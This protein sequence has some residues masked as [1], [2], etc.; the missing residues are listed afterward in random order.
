MK[1]RAD[2]CSPGKNRSNYNLPEQWGNSWNFE[3]VDTQSAIHRR[4]DPA[5]LPRRSNNVGAKVWSLPR[6]TCKLRSRMAR[7]SKKIGFFREVAEEPRKAQVFGLLNGTVAGAKLSAPLDF[8]LSMRDLTSLRGVPEPHLKAL[9]DELYLLSRHKLFL[10][11]W[12]KADIREEKQ[13]RAYR[14]TFRAVETRL[15]NAL[16]EI[17]SI[18]E[19]YPK[20]D[21]VELLFGAEEVRNSVMNLAD[22]LLAGISLARQKKTKALEFINPKLRTPREREEI[23]DAESSTH[24]ALPL[25]L[26]SPKIDHWFIGQADACLDKYQTAAQKQIPRHD[27]VISHLF[28]AAFGNESRD[29]ANIRKELRVQRKEGRP[30]LL[31]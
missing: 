27:K 30:H 26:K 17:V 14:K 2:W 24:V 29:P 25:R 20:F 10:E 28:S 31:S 6:E 13:F 4:H 15:S 19:Q 5:E 11:R 23:A 7:G 18:A 3:R 21:T 16:K 8:S 9:L 12:V 1:H 22:A